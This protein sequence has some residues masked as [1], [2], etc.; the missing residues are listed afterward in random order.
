MQFVDPRS[1]LMHFIISRIPSSLK[2]LIL[3]WNTGGRVFTVVVFFY[4]QALYF[5][6]NPVK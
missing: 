4:M 5:H 6:Q 2:Y 3:L 1:A